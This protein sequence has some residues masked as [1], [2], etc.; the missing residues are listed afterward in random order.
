MRNSRAKKNQSRRKITIVVIVVIL[1]AIAYAGTSFALEL[2][3][4]EQHTT[5]SDGT[6]TTGSSQ[7]ATKDNIPT[8][9]GGTTKTTDQ[10]PVDATL[11]AA[12]TTLQQADGFVTFSGTVTPA[13]TGGSCSVTLSNP[14]DKPVVRSVDA[15]SDANGTICGPIKIPES[16]FSYLGTWT[17]T[18]RYFVGDKQVVA[19]KDIVIQ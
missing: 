14:N 10:V 6:T 12:I 16:E 4:F 1:A 19:T 7:N 3:P 8:K 11:T 2:W 17:A 5:N 13:Q 9:E 18:F 15:T